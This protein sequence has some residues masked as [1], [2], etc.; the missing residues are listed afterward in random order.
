VN[1][2][3]EEKQDRW[4]P[5]PPDTEKTRELLVNGLFDVRNGMDVVRALLVEGDRDAAVEKLLAT[6][7]ELVDVLGNSL[8]YSADSP[9]RGE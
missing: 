5:Y 4:R 2:A 9:L 8:L 3:E 7:A 1:S 6:V